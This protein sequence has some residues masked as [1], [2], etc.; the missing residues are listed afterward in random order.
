MLEL[1]GCQ[2]VNWELG[3][4]LLQPFQIQIPTSSIP[5]ALAER[6]E[7][8]EQGTWSSVLD[9][10]RPVPAGAEPACLTSDGAGLQQG[11]GGTKLLVIGVINTKFLEIRTWISGKNGR[12]GSH[13][14]MFFWDM[15]TLGKVRLK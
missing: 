14:L 10:A 6:E 4:A 5:E 8:G 15:E 12:P 1:P 2:E 13:V 9:I 7:G 11:T 3:H